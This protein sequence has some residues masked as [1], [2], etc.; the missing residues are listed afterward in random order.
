MAKV[1]WDTTGYETSAPRT[2]EALPK[3]RYLASIDDTEL[4]DT[5]AKNGQ[6][7]EVT[8]VVLAP[9]EH[10]NRKLWARLN[11]KNSSE[12]AERIGR[13][14]FNALC[15]AALGTVQVAKTESLHNKK[16]IAHVSIEKN[17]ETGDLTNRIDG[18]E[19]YVPSQP[20]APES[21]PPAAAAPKPAAPPPAGKD[22]FEDDIPF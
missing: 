1:D 18:F 5:R 12:V 4:K 14:Q 8:L 21:A 22:D 13:E 11:V 16:V 15:M 7:L 9:K 6:Y 20:G 3:G 17:R 2:F 10:K 19:K